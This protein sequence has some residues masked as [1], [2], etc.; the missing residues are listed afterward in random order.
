MEDNRVSAEKKLDHPVIN[1]QTSNF[2]EL[3]PGTYKLISQI[4]K[5]FDQ[6]NSI[7]SYSLNDQG[8]QLPTDLSI[9]VEESDVDKSTS[10][11]YLDLI[12]K[13]ESDGKKLDSSKDTNTLQ[14][15]QRTAMVS[16]RDIQDDK[17]DEASVDNAGLCITNSPLDIISSLR[18]F[19]LSSS[20]TDIGSWS[21]DKDKI[22]NVK[23]SSQIKHFSSFPTDKEENILTENLTE[24]S[25]NSN[26]QSQKEINSY[27]IHSSLILQEENINYDEKHIDR[28]KRLHNN[29]TSDK[30]DNAKENYQQDFNPKHSSQSLKAW[31]NVHQESSSSDDND[32]TLSSNL[33]NDTLPNS[34]I[35]DIIAKYVY[36][37]R[38]GQKTDRSKDRNQSSEFKLPFDSKSSQQFHRNLLNSDSDSEL[39]DTLAEHHREYSQNLSNC[40]SEY[41]N[42]Q[43]ESHNVS[44]S[45]FSLTNM[46]HHF[47]NFSQIINNPTK[48]ILNSLMHSEE[49]TAHKAT[50][51]H[52]RKDYYQ[53]VDRA[54]DEYDDI[55]SSSVETASDIEKIVQ[56]YTTGYFPITTDPIHSK[57]RRRHYKDKSLHH[58]QNTK[59]SNV[60][61]NRNKKSQDSNGEFKYS[62]KSRSNA[63]NST[64]RTHAWSESDDVH[65]ES[66]EIYQN[67]KQPTQPNPSP[68]L[69]DN[70]VNKSI[71]T[72]LIDEYSSQRVRNSKEKPSKQ[73]EKLD[74]ESPQSWFIS[75]SNNKKPSKNFHSF[76]AKKVANVLSAS[77]EEP[78][79]VNVSANN[80]KTSHGKS[81]LLPPRSLARLTLQEAFQFCKADFIVRS[82]V[83]LRNAENVAKERRDKEEL[84]LRKHQIRVQEKAKPAAK[85]NLGNS[86]PLL[87]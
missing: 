64:H 18:S 71:Q 58:E 25:S 20:L 8:T 62:N 81:R 21:I 69:D 5:L 13:L 70:K 84:L 37:L 36:P 63:G 54:M 35:A 49:I 83:R 86:L 4:N 16:G 33:R 61:S 34:N 53:R 7:I 47:D 31:L 11:Q 43:S 48:H 60:E 2:K 82:K 15:K 41:K 52:K 24:D 78:L 67:F 45:S 50:S 19:N 3:S 51:K 76:P 46:P 55:R 12:S 75:L 74:Q 42:L 59:S 30:H 77:P 22:D 44:E 80:L 29:W 27:H 66:S 1:L 73:E 26:L 57:S 72:T 17:G 65:D 28:F 38:T 14:I 39:S 68:L 56:R 32:I 40:W 79:I 87:S 85:E 23:D 6:K 10:G 9:Q